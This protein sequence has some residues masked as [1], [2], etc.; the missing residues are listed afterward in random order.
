MSHIKH[1]VVGLTKTAA[2]DYAKNNIRI[3]AIA[4]GPI[5]TDLLN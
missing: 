1:G 2:L 5:N 3:N 4:P